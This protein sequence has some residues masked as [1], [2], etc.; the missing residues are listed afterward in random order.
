M[1]KMTVS[2]CCLL[3]TATTL[4]QQAKP[5]TITGRIVVYMTKPVEGAE[6]AVYERLHLNG[7]NTAKMIAPIVKTDRKGYFALQADVSSQYGICIVA[8][9]EGL[10]LAWDFLYNSLN[11]EKGHFPLVL[12]KACTVTGIVVNSNDKVVSGAKVRASPK[13]SY[14]SRLEQLHILAP[15]EWFTTATDSQGRFQFNQFTPDVCCDFSVEAPGFGSTYK[16]T[17]HSG[18]FEVWRSDIRLVLPREGHI[19]GRVIEAVTGKPVGDVELIVKT[20]IGWGEILNLYDL[21]T[22]KTD[23]NGAFEC[24]GLTEGKH[25]IELAVPE[26]ETARWIAKPVE[27]SVVPG[28]TTDGVQLLLEKGEFIACKVR[29][30]DSNQPVSRIRVSVYGYT[31]NDKSIT[32]EKGAAK[33]RVPPGE[34]QAY[35]SGEGYITWRVNEPV[36]VKD[37]EITHLDIL[38]DKSPMLKGSVVDADGR[39]A[40][41]VSVTNHPFGDQVYTDKEGMFAAGYD[42]ERAGQGI[43]VMARD[44]EH[45]LAALVRTKELK[46]PVELTLAPALT[47]KG[48]ITD[49]NGIGISAAR[50]SLCFHFTN[51]LSGMGVEVLT[52]PQGYFMFNTIPTVQSDCDYRIS[53]HAAGFG[54]KEYDRISIEGQSDTITVL[55]TIQLTPANA[56]I[57]GIVVDT[58]GLPAAQVPIFLREADG[59]DQPKKSTAT[60]KDGRFEIKRI[61]KG[62]LRLQ[63]NLYDLPGVEVG[64]LRAHGG[65]QDVKIILGQSG[66]HVPY[67]SIKDKPLP[68]LKDFGIK[69]SPDDIRGKMILLCFWDMQQRPSRRC[70]TQL[71]KQ[72]EQLKNKGITIIAV[73]AAQIDSEELNQWI[74]KYNIP[75]P[76]GMIKGN[77]EKTRFAWGVKSL[78]WLIL[79]DQK[80]IVETNGFSLEEKNEKI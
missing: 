9:K 41:D 11:N 58:N 40:K 16:F 38:L 55:Q 48:K 66:A 21:R 27:F 26:N 36:I 8:R 12:E 49:P 28:R 62:P 65:D 15:Q 6:V 7:E 5:F 29:E 64:N 70:M 57:S 53:V 20:N 51:C 30:Y 35:A 72:S 61:C 68:E 4:G 71:A 79:T 47:V 67:V 32:D 50:A 76:V 3:I 63:A 43:F 42:E 74:K 10:A 2:I 46:K 19:K 77:T 24:I 1:W 60:N 23:T 14:L 54:S 22:I 17:T 34:Y 44:P 45:S 31:G 39:P 75:F 56:S 18:G 78:P 37:G 73:Q 59:S 33:L 69:L 52:D 80:H 13:T 25:K